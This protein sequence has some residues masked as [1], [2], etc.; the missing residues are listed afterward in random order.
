[1]TVSEFLFSHQFGDAS[2]HVVPRPVLAPLVAVHAQ[3]WVLVVAVAVLHE[4]H[5]HQ[6]AEA[7]RA[8]AAANHEVPVLVA[9]VLKTY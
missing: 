4:R 1:M 3:T 5:L 6:R 7:A 2:P 9:S 8:G